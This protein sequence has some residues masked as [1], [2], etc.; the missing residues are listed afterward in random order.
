MPIPINLQTFIRQSGET[1]FTMEVIESQEDCIEMKVYPVNKPDNTFIVYIEKNQTY[2]TITN[3]F[4]KIY[5]RNTQPKRFTPR[6]LY[7]G[8]KAKLKGHK[9]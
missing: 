1:K 3:E 2:S 7:E 4:K 6:N 5:Q 8:T 9:K